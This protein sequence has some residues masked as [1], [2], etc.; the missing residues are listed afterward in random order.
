MFGRLP[1]PAGKAF[2]LERP[3]SGALTLQSITLDVLNGSRN[4]DLQAVANRLEV[5]SDFTAQIADR[6]LAY[7]SDDIDGA[8]AI[9]DSVG[10]DMATVPGALAQVH[11]M[12]AAME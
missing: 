10:P 4:E 5:A 2:H 8:R 1:D 7:G 9:S 6:G 3:Q 12:L 11:A